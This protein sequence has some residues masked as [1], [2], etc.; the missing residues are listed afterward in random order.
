[1]K[2]IIVTLILILCSLISISQSSDPTIEPCSTPDMDTAEFKQLPWFGNN[3]FLENFLDS[4]GYSSPGSG[5]R[6]VGAP[7]RYWIPIR[8]WVYRFDNGTGGP[9]LVQLQGLIDRLNQIFNQQNNTM[10]GFYMKCEPTFINSSEH[11]SKNFLGASLL[12]ATN[13]EPGCFNVHIVDDIRF[14]EGMALKP[15]G[16]CIIERTSF[17]DL[18]NFTLSHEIGHL[19]GLIHTHIFWDWQLKCFREC[20]SRTRTWPLLNLCIPNRLISLISKRVCESTGDA[21]R[22]T[23]ADPNLINNNTCAYTPQGGLW[24]T[25]LWG[26]SY[27]NPPN[28]PQER[29]STANVMSYQGL[30]QCVNNFSRLQIGVMLYHLLVQNPVNGLAWS[31]KIH[32][33]DV[34][35][36]DNEPV[37]ARNINVGIVQER[38][39]HQQL[40]STPL[41]YAP[42]ISQCD[43]DWVRF[44]PPCTQILN[45]TTSAM[46]GRVNADTRLT[47]F[48]NNMIQ[49]AQNDNISP[50]NSFSDISW[51]FVAGQVYFIR[52]ENMQNLVTGY[53]NLRVG[54]P[55][56]GQITGDD[57]VCGISNLYSITGLAPGSTVNWQALPQGIVTVNTPALPQTTITQNFSGNITLQATITH[58]CNGTITITKN[59]SVGNIPPIIQFDDEQPL[60]INMRAP[61]GI[62]MVR[63]ANPAPGTTYRWRVNGVI[64]G[65]AGTVFSIIHSWSVLGNNTVRAES[66][67]CGT[68][69]NS[70]EL[71]YQGEFCSIEGGRSAQFVISPNP[72]TSSLNISYAKNK[73]ANATQLP[74]I[75]EVVITDKFGKVLFQQKYISA[76]KELNLPVYQLRKDNYF[77]KIWDGQGWQALQFSKE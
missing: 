72:A 7:V 18:N 49:L 25:D 5:S 70:D 23:Q 2:K 47:L 20:V 68:W 38:N 11:M 63:V 14:A 56:P 22:D 19:L 69:E 16:A 41:I 29:P 21:L 39:F 15:L 40:N 65:N 27:D 10:I 24:A 1:M 13:R 76:R 45:I 59:V 60:C 33:F 42:F 51:N 3:D 35:E 34:F 55:N 58:P 30:N 26:D 8:F 61:Q 71:I 50:L 64:R 32:T 57:I 28:G 74:G 48:D 6:I 52:I 54:N 31:N 9:N 77:V 66:F 62:K 75:K 53:Y 12:M 4:I 37:L 67:R 73:L 17:T 43:V 44:V 36:P 46:Q